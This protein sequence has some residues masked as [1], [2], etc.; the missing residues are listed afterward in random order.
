MPE[1]RS[2]RH[3]D[4]PLRGMIGTKEKQKRNI[5]PRNSQD[6]RNGIVNGLATSAVRPWGL[7]VPIA[8][9]RI[10]F[11][12]RFANGQHSSGH[13]FASRMADRLLGA[14]ADLE[15]AACFLGLT[16]FP[17]LGPLTFYEFVA[18][19]FGASGATST[20]RRP[21]RPCGRHKAASCLEA[22]G[23][24]SP[25]GALPP[26]GWS[27]CRRGFST[28]IF[29]P[30]A[31]DGKNR[32]PYIDLFPVRGKLLNRV[33]GEGFRR[34]RKDTN[35]GKALRSVACGWWFTRSHPDPNGSVR[36]RDP[37]SVGCG[38]CRHG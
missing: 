21:C 11:P 31:I 9:L 30:L 36:S 18:E 12:A 32:H 4:P 8:A 5:S 34:N 25:R 6:R 38:N 2:P 10:R 22:W 3:R 33:L 7:I 29:H 14:P 13:R 24:E 20:K 23:F 28:A 16:S 35:V 27:F 17:Q 15:V 26:A 19:A 1:R 37:G